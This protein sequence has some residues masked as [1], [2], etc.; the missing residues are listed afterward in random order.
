MELDFENGSNRWEVFWVKERMA[1]SHDSGILPG[2]TPATFALHSY[3]MSKLLMYQ[4]VMLQVVKTWKLTGKS[5][6]QSTLE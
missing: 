2:D 4:V 1:L 6:Q 3:L 5:F